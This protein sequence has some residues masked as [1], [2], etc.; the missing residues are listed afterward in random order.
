MQPLLSQ[1]LPNATV[2]S[3]N[4][5]QVA[6]VDSHNHC[7]VMQ[8]F[9]LTTIAKSCNRSLSQPLPSLATVALT[10]IA[11]TWQW[12]LSQP[13]HDLAMVALTTIA[14]LQPNAQGHNHC[15]VNGCMTWQWL[16]P[17]RENGC[18][19]LTTIGNGCH[20]TVA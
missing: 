6:T 13:L 5:C 16:Q 18:M 14:N 11:M 15:Q 2:R 19:T 20:A 1:P 7:Q 10:T 8:P 9:A 3:H 12:L 4:H 17:L